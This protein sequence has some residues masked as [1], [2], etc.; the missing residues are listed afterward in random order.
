M[1]S[2]ASVFSGLQGALLLARGRREGVGYVS[3]DMRAAA[4]SF[5][6]ALVCAP[7]F[8]A[9][10]G[11]SWIQDG[12]PT[13]PVHAAALEFLSYVIGWAGYALISRPIVAAVRRA[14]HWPR[15]IAVWNWCNVVQYLL[16]V[17]A[18][19]PGLLDSGDRKAAGIAFVR[20]SIVYS[21]GLRWE[22]DRAE[23]LHHLARLM[24]GLGVTFRLLHAY[25]TARSS[26]ASIDDL[27]DCVT[28]DC[29]QWRGIF[30]A[31]ADPEVARAVAELCRKRIAELEG[32]A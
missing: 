12:Y 30:L 15:F 5:W 17:L 29:P 27:V 8:V 1:S 31:C 2:T 21:R 3:D 19:V 16:L 22:V 13:D 14:R 26:F 24:R 7:L 10:L 11:L 20:G 6:A 18:S 9:V 28:I 23:T 4:R 32:A 25:E